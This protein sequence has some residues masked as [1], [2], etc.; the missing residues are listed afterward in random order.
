MG[1]AHFIIPVIIY[2]SSLD[3]RNICMNMLGN[4]EY[5]Y[6]IRNVSLPAERRKTRDNTTTHKS[7][8]NARPAWP[9][10]PSLHSTYTISGDVLSTLVASIRGHCTRVQPYITNRWS[11]SKQVRKNIK[12]LVSKS[13]H[14]HYRKFGETMTEEMGLQM[15]PENRY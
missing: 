5:S 11:L 14:R 7:W 6:T 15:F 1:Y 12:I 4:W 9:N 10:S 13:L 2:S 3:I 8:W